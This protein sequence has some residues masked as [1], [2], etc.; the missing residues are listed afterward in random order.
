MAICVLSGVFGLLGF[1]EGQK[2]LIANIRNSSGADENPEKTHFLPQSGQQY[3]QQQR[4]KVAQTGK[5]GKFR[6]AQQEGN[7]VVHHLGKR[8]GIASCQGKPIDDQP[9]PKGNTE[10]KGDPQGAGPFRGTAY[11]V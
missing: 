1:K 5:Y 4:G 10:N 7:T 8:E 2:V 11:K 3:P 6:E 9:E